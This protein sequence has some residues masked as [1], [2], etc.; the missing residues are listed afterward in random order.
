[1]K[2]LL[3]TIE[4][5]PTYFDMVDNV[6]VRIIVAE[7]LRKQGNLLDCIPY[8]EYALRFLLNTAVSLKT[9]L[10]PNLQTYGLKHLVASVA[11]N[12]SV[13]YLQL[14]LQ[15]ESLETQEVLNT[16]E[17]SE[18][19]DIVS[20]Y[21]LACRQSLQSLTL[22][23]TGDY[24]AAHDTMTIA[25][26]KLVQFLP[27]NHT[28]LA[29]SL[30]QLG[31]LFALNGRIYESVACFD[32]SLAIYAETTGERSH[33]YIL[34]LYNKTLVSFLFNVASEKELETSLSKVIDFFPNNHPIQASFQ[35][36]QLIAK[37][38]C[39]KSDLINSKSVVWNY[40][41]IPVFDQPMG[42]LDYP[43]VSKSIILGADY[44]VWAH[45]DHLSHTFPFRYSWMACSFLGSFHKLSNLH[46]KLLKRYGKF[47]VEKH[48]VAFLDDPTAQKVQYLLKMKDFE[49]CNEFYYH[50]VVAGLIE[51]VRVYKQYANGLQDDINDGDQGNRLDGFSESPNLD[52]LQRFC[53][54]HANKQPALKLLSGYLLS[55][56]LAVIGLLEAQK[57]GEFD[58]DQTFTKLIT[59]LQFTTR[60]VYYGP[61]LVN[62][63]KDMY[64][65]RPH[66]KVT[67]NDLWVSN[68]SDYPG[69][70]RPQDQ[71]LEALFN[72]SA[73]NC[74]K[75]GTVQ[76]VVNKASLIQER[77]TCHAR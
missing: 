50:D 70:C 47:H 21:Q 55:D 33:Q 69:H 20:F 6:Y 19:G 46:A 77:E 44:Q 37:L 27:S 31:V 23:S 58:L 38:T 51:L 52:S 63:L 11:I 75:L 71:N 40:C 5:N 59:P 57:F 22:A 1:M 41:F 53:L 67:I 60:G 35:P 72:N 13:C 66:T 29:A 76:N 45:I 32:K 36:E 61:A 54:S 49:T 12:L 42:W 14:N 24:A 9:S 39:V 8:F 68:K 25:H 26:G 7:L 73:K 2:S 65:A 56:G 3:A 10:F 48:A 43:P 16:I 64:L 62:H 28:V 34:T 15:K 18:G 17:T 30:N 4:S 74:F